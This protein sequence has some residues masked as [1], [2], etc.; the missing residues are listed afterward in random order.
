MLSWKHFYLVKVLF[1]F[2]ALF[3]TTVKEF[4]ALYTTHLR[5]VLVTTF[6]DGVSKK[7]IWWL[8]SFL[9]S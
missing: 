2:A 6:G 5:S 4:P 1:I 8:V 7:P 9:I 3:D